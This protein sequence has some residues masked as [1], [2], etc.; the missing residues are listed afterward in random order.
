MELLRHL[1][2]IGIPWAIATSGSHRSAGP[3]LA[4][5]EIAGDTVVITHDEVPF[6]K[7]DPHLFLTAAER[8]GVN[9]QNAIVVGDSVWDMLAA[10]TECLLR[11]DPRL[12]VG[13][14]HHVAGQDQGL[15][16][17]RVTLLAAALNGLLCRTSGSLGTLGHRNE[18]G[19]VQTLN[20]TRGRGGGTAEPTPLRS[21]RP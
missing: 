11:R 18:R 5:L 2:E 13:Q 19:G 10:P 21:T 3:G 17:H 12:A 16:H 8:L 14:E 15:L 20:M 4:L 7:P 6:A 9:I 1:T